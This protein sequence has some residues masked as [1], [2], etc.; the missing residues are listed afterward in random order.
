M[1]AVTVYWRNDPQEMDLVTGV[2]YIS[3][4]P[5]GEQLI[6]T[7]E[8][9]QIIRG[10]ARANEGALWVDSTDD[11]VPDMAADLIYQWVPQDRQKDSLR[12]LIRIVAQESQQG[13]E[14]L[15]K[16]LQDRL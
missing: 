2:D 4:G 9:A 3:V 7:D 11:L 12:M 10:I 16:K 15:E 8:G 5:D 13:S 1:K 6:A 14:E